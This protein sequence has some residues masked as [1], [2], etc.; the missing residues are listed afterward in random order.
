[1]EGRSGIGPVEINDLGQLK[2]QIAGEIRDFDARKH[3][4]R[5]KAI[6]LMCREVSVACAAA[7]MAIEDAELDTQSIDSDRFGVIMGS[8]M[9]YGPPIELAEIHK[10]SVVDGDFSI[11]EFGRRMTTDMFPLW[12]LKYLPNMSAC[13][14]GIEHR[15]HGANN[16]I[17]QGVCFG[18]AGPGRSHFGDSTWLV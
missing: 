17:V 3:V 10:N 1:M 13:H 4:K 11:R 8:E 7:N 12:L 2:H 14:I 6:K 16:T 9:F 5:R 18:V 15:A